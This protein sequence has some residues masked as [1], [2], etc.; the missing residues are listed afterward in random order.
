MTEF[1]V[2]ET[3]G[4]EMGQTFTSGPF[5]KAQELWGKLPKEEK[6]QAQERFY[7]AA[8]S[9]QAVQPEAEEPKKK[10]K[11]KEQ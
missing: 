3:L 2:F 6:Q 10:K 5:S 7:N 1:S 9:V 11:K 8:M 4:K